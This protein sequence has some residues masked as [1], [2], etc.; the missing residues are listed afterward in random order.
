MYCSC[1]S[2]DAISDS[3]RRAPESR[4][5]AR[6][7]LRST[8][9]SAML[10]CSVTISSAFNRTLCLA[11]EN[12]VRGPPIVLSRP[13]PAMPTKTKSLRICILRVDTNQH[14]NAHQNQLTKR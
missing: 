9:F 14:G 4:S 7:L 2:S 10:S 13:S 1:E 8:L 3:S 12:W 11:C 5:E 6:Y